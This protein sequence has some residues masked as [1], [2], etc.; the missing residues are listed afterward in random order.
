MHHVWS[1]LPYEIGNRTDHARIRRG[2]VEWPLGVSVEAAECPAPASNSM[3]WYPIIH[4]GASTI[5][6][7]Q[8]DNFNLMTTT[9][10]LVCEQAHV[11]VAPTGQGWRV[12][13]AGL[14]DAHQ[15]VS[16]TPG[17]RARI[18]AVMRPIC[19]EKKRI[20]GNRR[21]RRRLFLL[22]PTEE[23]ADRLLTVRKFAP[24]QVCASIDVTNRIAHAPV[25]ITLGRPQIFC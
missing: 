25:V 15:I 4:F 16:T 17:L 5:W 9:G 21:I 13:V 12:T 2:W 8:R 22:R 3:N 10:K 18:T 11:E 20:A 7:C 19:A 14:E 1:A 6:S 23:V 24:K